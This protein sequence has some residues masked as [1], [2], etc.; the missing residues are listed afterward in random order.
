M[1]GFIPL[2]VGSRFYGLLVGILVVCG[3]A[4][5][6][7]WSPIMGS[8]LVALLGG[9]VCSSLADLMR[10]LQWGR[11][12]PILVCPVV[13]FDIYGPGLFAGPLFSSFCFG[14]MGACSPRLLYFYFALHEG[15]SCFV[16]GLILLGC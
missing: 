3:P 7:G 11:Q 4:G 12:H 2:S 16:Y 6:A 15:Y 1:Q 10:F 8:Q 5:G 9:L 13:G 14:L